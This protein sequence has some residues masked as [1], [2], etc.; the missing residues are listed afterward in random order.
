MVALLRGEFAVSLAYTSS[1]PETAKKKGE[2]SD[3]GLL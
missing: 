3:D 2:Y 1:T